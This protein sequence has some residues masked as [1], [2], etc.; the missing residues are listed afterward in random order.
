APSRANPASAD[1]L[2]FI[3]TDLKKSDEHT[4]SSRLAYAIHQK[5]IAATKAQDRGVQ[6]APLHVLAVDCP[7]VLVELGFLSHPQESARLKEAAYQERL[8]AEIAEAVKG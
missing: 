1:P 5:L 4:Q 2:S 6:Q 8:A 7:A 3:L